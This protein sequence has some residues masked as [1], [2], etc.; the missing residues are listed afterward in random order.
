MPNYSKL[1]DLVS[2]RIVVEYDTGAR[3]V[4]Y[5]AGVKPASG[6]V[7]VLNLSRAEVRAA[8]GSLLEQHDAL[9]ICPNVLTGF[10]LEEG[11]AGRGA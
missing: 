6:P 11:P 3:I 5:V 10:H 4:G 2:H 9:S 1:R 8:D 7:Q